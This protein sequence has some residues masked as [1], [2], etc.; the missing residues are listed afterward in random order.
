MSDPKET[1]YAACPH[2]RAKHR[3]LGAYLERW[4]PILD[5]NAQKIG[6]SQ[7]RLLYV[8]GFAGAGE[9]EGG[10]PGSPQVAIDVVENHSHKFACPIEVRFIEKRSDRADHLRQVIKDKKS[11]LV[12]GMSGLQ[13][14]EPVTG[15]CEPEILRLIEECASKRQVLG[16][17]FFFLDQFGYSSFSMDLIARILGHEVCE[18][19]S[20]LNW[21]LLHPFMSD[22][23]KH[24]GISKA[25]G[26]DEWR[27]VL[28]LHGAEK[29]DKF[30]EVYLDALRARGG[31]K[32]AYPFAMRGPDHRV[33]YW[34]FFCTNNLRG[35]EEMKRAMWS[36]DRSGGFEFSDKFAS[37][38]S[39]LFEYGD[40]QLAADLVK[41]L[42]G[43]TLTVDQFYEHAIV[44]TPACSCLEA[45]GLME[46][47]GQLRAVEPPARRRAGSFGKYRS[48]HVEIRAVSPPVK[49]EQASLFGE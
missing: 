2:T 33:I 23:N 10:I 49:P 4:L 15:E 22:P 17:A 14:V 1:V 30:R 27:D 19:F 21:S 36:V 7:Q 40:A 13:I 11:K 45:F 24:A 37:E 20:Y 18:T 48:M 8:D 35:L 34:L 6:R 42:A 47:T 5:R 29:E 32:Y 41:D 12:G 25:F 28:A 44:N 9:Y 31:A 39:S 26:G 43:K 3:I 38:R 16:P 46:R